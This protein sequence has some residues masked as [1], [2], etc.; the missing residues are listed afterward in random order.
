MLLN[1]NTL[2]S[3]EIYQNQ[4]DY[5]VK[6]SLFWTMDRTKTRFGQRLLR[7]WVGRPLIDRERLEERIAAVEELK[8]ELESSHYLTIEMMSLNEE[9]SMMLLVLKQGIS[10][11][12]L[13]LANDKD[14]MDLITKE[15]EERFFQL[16]KQ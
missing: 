15:R 16:M 13:K 10:E 12:Q 6:G 1:G 11:A 5:T 9:M 7:K 2:S 4:T 3:L 8:M 14:E